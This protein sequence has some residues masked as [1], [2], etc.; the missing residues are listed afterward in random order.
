ML[1]TEQLEDRAKRLAQIRQ[2]PLDK[3]SLYCKD[4]PGD[5]K[6]VQCL[7]C[8][9]SRDGFSDTKD[10]WASHHFRFAHWEHYFA[11]IPG[12]PGLLSRR[13]REK[14]I[15]WKKQIKELPQPQ[16][17]GSSAE[18]W[19]VLEDVTLDTP[20]RTDEELALV[21]ETASQVKHFL[22]GPVMIQRFVVVSEGNGHC[23]CLGINT[24]VKFF[25]MFGYDVVAN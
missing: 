3:M 23:L 18:K 14:V 10:D 9:K 4:L 19:I 21:L 7:L 25:R 17:S 6:R 24:W 5:R 22:A 13:K 20:I 16:N 15:P 11:M 8:P 2:L 1:E 12:G